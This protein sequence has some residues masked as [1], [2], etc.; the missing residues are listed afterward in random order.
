MKLY[1]FI[2][3]HKNIYDKYASKRFLPFC[4]TPM[5]FF[6]KYTNKSEDPRNSN[7]SS[8]YSDSDFRALGHVGNSRGS[9]VVN[10]YDV[11]YNKV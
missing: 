4:K 7:V 10:L 2:K 1:Y 3:V 6:W 11:I 8:F 9:S 5:I